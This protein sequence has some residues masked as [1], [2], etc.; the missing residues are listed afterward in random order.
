MVHGQYHEAILL[1]LLL[2]L[3]IIYQHEGTNPHDLKLI[4]PYKFWPNGQYR[5]NARTWYEWLSERH[6]QES[7]TALSFV[8]SGSEVYQ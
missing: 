2:K 7:P 4:S 3:L 1:R 5:S 6:I 8:V